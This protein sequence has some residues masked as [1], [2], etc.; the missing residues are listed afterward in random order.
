M[1]GSRC[2][3]GAVACEDDV[4]IFFGLLLVVIA[5]VWAAFW[6]AGAAMT[7][8]TGIWNETTWVVMGIAALAL[9]PFVGGICLLARAALALRRSG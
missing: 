7:T 2:R 9:V 8:E 6:S 3:A 1:R 5:F 4:R